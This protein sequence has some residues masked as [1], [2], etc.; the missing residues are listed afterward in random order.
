MVVPET[1]VAVTAGNTDVRYAHLVEHGTVK[2]HAQPFFWP[3]VRMHRKK[4]KAAIKRAVATA[5]KKE[6]GK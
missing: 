1:S 5:V 4:A 3:A 6:W 2:A